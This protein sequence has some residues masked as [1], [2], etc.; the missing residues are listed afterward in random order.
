MKVAFM[1]S[2]RS[3]PERA[4]WRYVE[5]MTGAIVKVLSAP[6]PK[7]IATLVAGIP[8]FPQTS[9]NTGKMP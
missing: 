2:F 9:I 4:R 5:A 6:I 3:R 7:A 1:W 8:Y